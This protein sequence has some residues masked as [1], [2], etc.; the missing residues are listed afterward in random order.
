[1]FRHNSRGNRYFFRLPIVSG[2]NP[3]LNWNNAEKEDDVESEGRKKIAKWRREFL[4]CVRLTYASYVNLLHP[5]INDS[6]AVA[7][8]RAVE[9][10]VRVQVVQVVVL[11]AGLARRPIHY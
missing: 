7:R 4:S 2:S 3:D 1:M 9:I 5:G 10:V 8:H 6:L 11:R